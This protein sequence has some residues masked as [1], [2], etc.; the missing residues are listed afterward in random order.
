MPL[1]ENALVTFR[2]SVKLEGNLKTSYPWGNSKV[3]SKI[4]ISHL[5]PRKL[6]YRCD[7][8]AALD[9]FAF[10]KLPILRTSYT[11]EKKKCNP[12]LALTTNNEM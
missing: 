4:S 3:L 5:Y 8:L 11:K 10:E 9:L 6:E 1:L 12:N 2:P 7:G